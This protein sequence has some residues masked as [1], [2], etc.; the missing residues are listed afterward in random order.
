MN[1]E[2]FT[3]IAKLLRSKDPVRTAAML[4][5]VD[6]K[7][8][9]EAAHATGVSPSSVSNSIKRFRNTDAEIRRVYFAQENINK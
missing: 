8:G 5:L 9:V 7:T 3:L 2:E 4:V 1:V 6:G